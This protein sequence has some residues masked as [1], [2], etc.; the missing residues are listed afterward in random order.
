MKLSS[1][2]A[3]ADRQRGETALLEILLEPNHDWKHNCEEHWKGTS[4][5]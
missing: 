3:S 2:T 1:K 5:P 4:A